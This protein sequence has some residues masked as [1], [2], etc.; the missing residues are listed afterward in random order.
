[1]REP[2]DFNKKYLILKG[3]LEI[4]GSENR[5]SAAVLSEL[6]LKTQSGMVKYFKLFHEVQGIKPYLLNKLNYGPWARPVPE[7]DIE[8]SNRNLSEGSK[9]A[10]F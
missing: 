9:D 2:I 1:M 4:T 5:S 6:I 3:N 8:V 7:L 10:D